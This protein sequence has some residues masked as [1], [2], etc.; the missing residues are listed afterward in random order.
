MT[1]ISRLRFDS[2]YFLNEVK[3]KKIDRQIVQN[4]INL[5][6]ANAI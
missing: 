5:F 2:N 4:A 1:L 3:L 6:M